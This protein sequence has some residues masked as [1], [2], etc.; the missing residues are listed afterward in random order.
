MGGKSCVSGHRAH[1]CHRNVDGAW[2]PV[3]RRTKSKAIHSTQYIVAM[4]VLSCL[5]LLASLMTSTHAAFVQFENCLP[6]AITNSNPRLLQFTPLN[7]SAV[8]D[9]KDPKH[10]LNLTIYGNVS[11]RAT[12]Q[13]LPPIDSPLW[14]EP[15]NTLGKIPDVNELNNKYT[16]LFGEFDVLSYIP[17]TAPASQFCLSTLNGACPLPPAFYVNSSAIAALPGFTVAHDMGS[18]YSFATIVPT[19]QVKSGDAAGS[20]LACVSANITP[21]LGHTLRNLIR[22]LP[23]VVLISVAVA[24]IVAATYSPWGTSDVFRWSSNYGR[25]EDLLRL[26]TPGFADCLGYIQFIFLTGSLSLSYPGY[27]QPVV[28]QV[29]WSSLMFNESFVTHGNG[30]RSLVDGIYTVNGT[31]GLEN[32]IQ[33]IGM[34]SGK[35]AWAG[36]MSFLLGILTIVAGFSQL[37]FIVRWVLRR[38]GHKE[39]EDL[40]AKNMPFTVGNVIRIVFNFFLLPIVSLS[41]FQLV[42]APEGPAYVVALA[43]VVL[44]IL[45]L[46][47]GWIVMLFARTPQRSHLFD[48]LPTVLLYG[49]LYNTYSDDA[50]TF[51][52][53]PLFVNILR[54]VAIGAVQ[55]SGIAQIILLAVSEIILALT[56]NAFRPFPSPTS[57]NVY[58]TFFALIRLITILM[59]IAFVPSLGVTEGP[60]GWI[61][62]VMLLMH[63]AVLVLGFFLNAMSTLIEVGARLAGAGGEGG[64]AARG[65]L[66]K[67]FGARQLSRRVPQRDTTTRHSMASEAAML[68]HDSDQKSVQLENGRIRS[69]SATSAQLLNRS[70][71]ASTVYDS[72]SAGLRHSRG[73]GSGQYTPSSPGEGPA[74]PPAGAS[75]NRASMSP[76]G[77]VGLKQVEAADPFYRAPRQR[78]NTMDPVSPAERSRGSWATS[79]DWSKR[80][81]SRQDIEAQ[82]DED[83]GEGPSAT[84]REAQRPIPEDP[85]EEGDEDLTRT[86]T[87]YAIR[88]VDFYYGVRGPALSS[89]TRK[90]KTGPADPTGPVSSATGW[91]KGLL[92]G[93]TKDKGKGFEVVRSSRVPPPGL[94]PPVDG[95]P[96]SP[97]PYRGAEPYKDEPTT[98]TE[99]KTD[100]PIEPPRNES[101]E[102]EEDLDEPYSDVDFDDDERPHSYVSPIPPSLPAIDT[103]GDIE[104]PSRIGSRASRLSRT[105]S[106]GQV[107]AIPRKSSRRGSSADYA[108]SGF[109]A[110]RLPTVTA[111]PPPSPKGAGHR[112]D[113]DNPSQRILAPSASQR[114]PFSPLPNSSPAKTQT[115]L[116]DSAADSSLFQL[117]DEEGRASA[118]GHHSRNS[119]S[120]LGQLAPN[121]KN[122]RPSSM[123]YVAQHRAGE[124]IHEASPD[125]PPLMESSAEFVNTPP[126]H[127]R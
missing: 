127:A 25:D 33:L 3:P 88:E 21:D 72:A 63:A 48:D 69:S 96:V 39:E 110:P 124:N 40:R 31:Y 37:G 117:A 87:D 97:E 73:S 7:V 104:L 76:G 93:K 53:I 82:S 112:Y 91:F 70:D 92:G 66:T 52:L 20:I 100:H 16:T 64:R 22:Y 122:D 10:N 28:S 36:M 98:P 23:L 50:A 94:M 80:A 105:G 46:F 125:S 116:A 83:V 95:P 114:L 13:P 47:T 61:G 42:L 9:T 84:N 68:G 38:V 27:Y 51:A 75:R 32:T 78:R 74:F 8:F 108:K 71:R 49:P 86:K 26:V 107:P 102:S 62:Y 59:C 1:E 81:T 55:P 113:P 115:S 18:S 85:L 109:P 77:L 44:A 120:A 34:T 12:D 24:T 57:M 2:V 5:M 54:G 119:S 43:I 118:P 4:Q 19:F 111:S 79:G 99:A 121:V 35:D 89:G 65:G 67:V 45:I 60:K 15:N 58:H 56:L 41:M 123:G 11:G 30:S 14:S 103:G 126:F 106:K 17:Y 29:G 6:A 101:E 90:L